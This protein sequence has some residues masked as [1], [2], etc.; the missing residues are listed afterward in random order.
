MKRL[1]MAAVMLPLL[2]GACS[3]GGSG[4]GGMRERLRLYDGTL[5][6]HST[7]GAGTRL[8]AVVPLPAG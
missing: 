7:P 3:S 6:M 5:D 1:A 8:R 4:L 2:L